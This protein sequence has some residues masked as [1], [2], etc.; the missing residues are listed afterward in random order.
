MF[1]ETHAQL[2]YYLF[3]HA[4][5]LPTISGAYTLKQNF[6]RKSQSTYEAFNVLSDQPSPNSASMKRY[7]STEAIRNGTLAGSSD[8]LAPSLARLV[9]QSP[10][11]PRLPMMDDSAEG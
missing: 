9:A 1:L 2:R 8:N 5:P 10:T 4:H 11:S 6:V 7:S 3:I